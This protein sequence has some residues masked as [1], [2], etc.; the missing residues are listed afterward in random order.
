MNLACSVCGSGSTD[1]LLVSGPAV[2]FCQK[3]IFA[4]VQLLLKGDLV[5]AESARAPGELDGTYCSFC[6][7]SR[8]ETRGMVGYDG[9]FFAC[10]ECLGKCVE[11]VAD[12]AIQ[13]A[14]VVP[15][16]FAIPPHG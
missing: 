14:D 2:Y 12:R 16:V 8:R 7:K 3:C 13:Q 10:T 15:L 9:T 6:G 1:T 11:I 4:S 5:N